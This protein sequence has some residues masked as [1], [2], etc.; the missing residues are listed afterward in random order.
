MIALEILG[1]MYRHLLE[2]YPKFMRYTFISIGIYI[3][4]FLLMLSM[5]MDSNI[6]YYNNITEML[7]TDEYQITHV[8]KDKKEV[9]TGVTLKVEKKDNFFI[10]TKKDGSTEKITFKSMDPINKNSFILDEISNIKK[11]GI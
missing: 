9:W 6:Y 8:V 7:Y 11:N 1:D 4:Y 5:K 3:V 2:N 10:I